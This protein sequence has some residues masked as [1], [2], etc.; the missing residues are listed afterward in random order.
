MAIVLVPIPITD[1]A[2]RPGSVPE[3]DAVA[4]EVAWTSGQVVA[5]GAE[6]VYQRRVWKCAVVPTDATVPPNIDQRSWEDM[7]PSNRWA[8][9]DNEVQTAGVGRKGSAK[10]VLFM[11]F[12]SGIAVHNPIGN[13]LTLT[14]RD[15]D[16]G[17]DLSPPIDRSLRASRPSLWNYLYGP[18]TPVTSFRVDGIT[19]R[20]RV[21][22]TLEVTGGAT[23]DVGVGFFSIGSWV[24]MGLFTGRPG[25]LYTARAEVVNYTTRTEGADGRYRQ[26]PRGSATNLTLPVAINPDDANRIWSALVQL[27]DT[28]VSVFASRQ[29]KF[30]YLSSVGFVTSDLSPENQAITKANIFVKGIV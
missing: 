28:P 13:R 12:V 4:G 5:V 25:V 14:V 29:E 2:F 7:R 1:A 6:R 9:F 24:T 21:L 30:R 3:V 19:L 11:R 10:Y 27:K 18:K 16:T 26:V 23:D 15:A 22:V 20:P 17:E 8:P